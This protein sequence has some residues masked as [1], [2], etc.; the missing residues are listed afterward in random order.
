M[1][2]DIKKYLDEK[3]AKR[4]ALM[5]EKEIQE[6][7]QFIEWYRQA[8]NDKKDRNLFAKWEEIEHYWEGDIDDDIL[9]SS[10]PASNTNITNSNVEGKVALLCDQNIAVQVDP[11]EPSDRP[12]CD[13]VRIIADFIKNRNYMYQKIDVHE[14]RREMFGSG[15][16]RVLWNF[17]ELDGLG[18]PEIQPVSPARI[19]V[20]PSITDVYKI[21]E[22]RYIIEVFNK[23]IYS[24]RLKYGDKV[25]DAIVANLDPIENT[26]KVTEE[27]Q[28]L[29]M[30]IW[31]RYRD[32]KG[33]IMLRLIEMT[34]CGVIL[35]DTKKKLEE[36]RQKSQE[37]TKK[38]KDKLLAEGKVKEADKLK[39]DEEIRLFPNDTYPYFFTP[40]M[41]RENSIWGKGSAELVIPI[42][43]QVDELDNQILNSARLTG[44]PV[45]LVEN[46]SGID[47]DKI[48]NE[49]GL[50]I[51]TNN[52]NGTRWETPPQM[53][54]YIL[55]K[56]TELMNYD[57]S[58]ITRF[59]DQMIGNKQKGV[60]TATE[61]LALQTSGNSMIEH[62]KGLL[63]V[64][65]SKV[66]EYA[67]ELAILNWDTEMMFR[68][69]GNSGETQFESFTPSSLND[70][71]L[72]IKSNTDYQNK[73][74]EAHK[75][76]KPEDYEYMQVEGETRKVKYDLNV[77]VGAG[78]PNNKAFRY[79]L[80]AESYAK[81]AITKREY[82]KYLIDN[83]GLNVPEIPESEAE[84]QE[85][86]IFSD[87]TIEKMQAQTNQDRQTGNMNN[88]YQT[89]GADIQGINANG[90]IAPSQVR[91]GY[92]G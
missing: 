53:P 32:K 29:H 55:N 85:L 41:Y 57:R 13:R 34:G 5:S 59:N 18:L 14:R 70:I 86:G 25:A 33:N 48:T 50:V 69:T 24:A 27:E 90:N 23:S 74:K 31:T 2:E 87:E 89:Q 15:I 62:K 26:F 71:P 3:E 37:E 21:Q 66:F 52:I 72:L 22:A 64:T 83:L 65:L 7:D 80:I 9:D 20:D 61:S 8:Y 1:E 88:T 54:T 28:Y 58:V 12:F 39:E 43:D 10:E 11:V 76:A 56:R 44:N 19:C 17:K 82:R 60:D 42:S 78:M 81:Q 77:T 46:S 63:Q 4:K 38:K 84:Q 51:P 36:Q 49:P 75:D 47:C 92:N 6:A 16:F 40:D 67:V 91:E 45:R 30:L 68:I 79:N 35:S 73:Y